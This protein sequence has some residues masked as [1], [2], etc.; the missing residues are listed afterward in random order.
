[1]VAFIDDISVYS[2]IWE[3]HERHL[4]IV[5]QT[6]REC[7][8][9]LSSKDM[10]SIGRNNLSRYTIFKEEIVIDSTKVEAV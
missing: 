5:L 7:Q 10:S 6:P 8:L 9:S 1:M 4:M 3:K 2:N